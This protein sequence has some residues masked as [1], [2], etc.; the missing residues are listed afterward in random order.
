M[1]CCCVIKSGSWRRLPTKAQKS[2]VELY[3]I[4]ILTFNNIDT[5][6]AAKTSQVIVSI[7]RMWTSFINCLCLSSPPNI[8]SLDPTSVRDC[9][10][11]ATWSYRP[12]ERQKLYYISFLA[13]RKMNKCI[14]LFLH[15]FYFLNILT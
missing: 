3:K 10:P 1:H 7:S 11:R 13:C 5:Y 4:T 12:I 2:D 6:V 9:P 8:I 14:S 15:F